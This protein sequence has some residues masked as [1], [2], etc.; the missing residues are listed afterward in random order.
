LFRHDFI[1]VN[2]G[3]FRQDPERVAAF[4]TEVSDVLR[5]RHGADRW[6]N[7]LLL[8]TEGGFFHELAGVPAG[9]GVSVDFSHEF[10][11]RVKSAYVLTDD[12][13]RQLLPGKGADLVPLK[14]TS[15]GILYRNEASPCFRGH[16]KK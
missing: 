9:F 8:A 12:V 11:G 10:R 16:M 3:N 14:P 7:T 1:A 2:A 6:C 15:K 4:S 5:Y 13:T